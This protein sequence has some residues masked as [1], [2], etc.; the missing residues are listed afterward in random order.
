ERCQELAVRRAERKRDRHHQR[1]LIIPVF[2][3]SDECLDGCTDKAQI[4]VAIIRVASGNMTDSGLIEARSQCSGEEASETE[5]AMTSLR[6]KRMTQRM[7]RGL[8]GGSA[9]LPVIAIAGLAAASVLT[10][11]PASAVP[12]AA[13][14]P[15][16]AA[17]ASR[18]GSTP[19]DWVK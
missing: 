14:H 3:K 10:A 7:K 16:S 4:Y 18:S 19:A 11:A 12:V 6:R 17:L 9:G 1:L 5:Q 8:L 13:A 15:A 2:G